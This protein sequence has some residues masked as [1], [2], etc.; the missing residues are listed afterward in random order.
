MPFYNAVRATPYIK[1]ALGPYYLSDD[2]P[3]ATALY[4]SWKTCKFVED[5]GDV[6]FYK[7]RTELATARG[8]KKL[9]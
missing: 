6:V 1:A 4:R 8:G 5:E 9:E 3:I 7:P 2:T